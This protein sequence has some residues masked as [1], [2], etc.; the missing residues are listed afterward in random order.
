LTRSDLSAD[1]DSPWG[2]EEE[3]G[4]G[5]TS[6][7]RPASTMRWEAVTVALAATSDHPEV[8]SEDDLGVVQAGSAEEDLAA[9]CS[10][11]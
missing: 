2:R 7:L 9:T 10:C 8:E 5:V 3:A 1:R 11:E 4:T 6:S